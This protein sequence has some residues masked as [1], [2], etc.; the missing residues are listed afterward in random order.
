MGLSTN[1]K[2][3]KKKEMSKISSHRHREKLKEA[4]AAAKSATAVPEVTQELIEQLIVR[5][6]KLQE[7]MNL[8]MAVIE[9]LNRRVEELETKR[10]PSTA[11]MFNASPFHLPETVGNIADIAIADVSAKSASS[12]K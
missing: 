9:G 3:I 4:K 2:E 10:N 6:D 1:S 8:S 12:L 11:G 7:G 5:V